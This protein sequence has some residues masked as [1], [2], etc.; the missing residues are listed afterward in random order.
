MIVSADISLP[1]SLPMVLIYL[2]HESNNLLH[3]GAKVVWGQE[4]CIWGLFWVS[5]A[6]VLSR[7][8]A[9]MGE[10]YE[11]LGGDIIISTD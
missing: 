10:D 8:V 9:V 3:V 11:I 6:T 4:T 7:I 1:L 5:V 2:S